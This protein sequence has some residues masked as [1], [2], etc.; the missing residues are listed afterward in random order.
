MADAVRTCNGSHEAESITDHGVNYINRSSCDLY[1]E[2]VPLAVQK[3][4]K[5]RSAE[6]S[7]SSSDEQSSVLSEPASTSSRQSRSN[8]SESRVLGDRKQSN[9]VHEEVG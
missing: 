7:G 4:H 3:K 5:D 1:A 9:P 2:D 8:D 6:G